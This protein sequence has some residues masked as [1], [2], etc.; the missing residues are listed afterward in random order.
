MQNVWGRGGF[1][2]Y[3]QFV[4]VIIL[5][6][7][8]F[9]SLPDSCKQQIPSGNDRKKSKSHGAQMISELSAATA[10]PPAAP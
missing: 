5:L 8:F 4:Q 9:L 2:G 10:L 6:L 7:S 3:I 1:F